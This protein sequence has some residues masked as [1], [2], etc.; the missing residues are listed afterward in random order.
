[1]RILLSLTMGMTVAHAMGGSPQR[2]TMA[3]RQ[4]APDPAYCRVGEKVVW[5]VEARL[6]HPTIGGCPLLVWT[7]TFPASSPFKGKTFRAETKSEPAKAHLPTVEPVHH[8][9]E[10]DP[11]VADRDGEHKYEVKIEALNPA[12]LL[13]VVSQDDPMLVVYQ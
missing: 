12:G 13:E 5:L 2:S 3:I 8:A 6:V 1:M 10:I 11:G 4:F 9:G 7:V